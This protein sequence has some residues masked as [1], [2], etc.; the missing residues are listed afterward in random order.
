MA[1]LQKLKE[2]C[3][4]GD[5][6]QP[7]DGYIAAGWAALT[8]PPR[9]Y[10]NWVENTRDKM[11]NALID[12]FAACGTAPPQAVPAH[13]CAGYIYTLWAS[14]E[15]KPNYLDTTA[16]IQD[17]CLGWDWTNN[18]PR[19][20]VVTGNTTISRIEA[21]WDYSDSP[22]MSAALTLNFSP[23]PTRILAICSD[24]SYLYVLYGVVD[25]LL[26]VA[27][28]STITGSSTPV[29][30]IAA[31]GAFNPYHAFDYLTTRMILADDTHLGI[32]RTPYPPATDLEVH[33]V[34]TALSTV[35]SELISGGIFPDL[36]G[37]CLATDGTLMYFIGFTEIPGVSR[38]YSL[39]RFAI[40]DLS[41]DS[42]PIATV[43]AGE[44]YWSYQPTGM[45]VVGENVVISNALGC[46]WIY[47]M[48]DHEVYDV[49]KVEGSIALVDPHDDYGIMLG[50]DGLNVW[51][52][53][54]ELNED[55]AP[56]T[57]HWEAYKIS[58]AYFNRHNRNTDFTNVAPVSRVHI[59]FD[60]VSS[61]AP[62]GRWVFDGRD[63][64]LV[65]R[66][67]Q[68]FRICAPGLR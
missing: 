6:T 9:Q 14:P 39:Y 57:V 48:L 13:L 61:N 30:T 52:V 50:F 63:M 55:P 60:D 40:S 68:I 59:D 31:G 16:T 4:T 41:Y 43:A 49:A 45:V 67:G 10:W 64:W 54:L 46:L 19:L 3:S 15:L 18:K 17:V 51:G 24:A 5:K 21:P 32:V 22:E 38:D 36:R 28:F 26:Y 11:I 12:L 29:A 66:S 58:A 53:F 23:A 25:S 33:T 56:D 35:Q 62:N 37:P 2:W 8:R 20:Y 47:S 1:M 27:K 7:S 42:F 44:G 34:D 65:F